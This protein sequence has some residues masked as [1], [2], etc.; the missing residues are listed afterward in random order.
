[1]RKG[2]HPHRRSG[3][4]LVGGLLLAGLTGPALAADPIPLNKLQDVQ[5]ELQETSERKRELDK[6]AARLAAEQKALQARLVNSARQVQSRETAVT[7]GEEKL[8]ALNAQAVAKQAALQARRGELAQSLAGLARLTRQPP[9]AMLLAP[10][11]ALDMVRATQ[12]VSAVVP[13]VQNRASTLRDDLAELTALRRAAAAEQRELVEAAAAMLDDRKKLEALQAET[14]QAAQSTAAERAEAVERATRLASEAKDLKSLV[15]R[16]AEEERQ[17]AKARAEREARERVA[18]LP[19]PTVPDS[20][21]LREGSAALPA[22]GRLVRKY[23]ETDEN[24]AL[25]KGIR[26][27]TRSSAQVVA[28]ADGKIVFAGPFRGYGQLLII[29]HGGGYH[30]LLAGFARIDRTVGQAVQAGEPVGQM[31]V[32]ETAKPTL[33][34]ELRLRGEPINPLPWLAAGERKVNG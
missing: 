25:L 4:L 21:N 18:R 14:N 2:D 26:I 20:F 32:D 1:M 11:S 5:R 16:L 19:P 27:E 12:L 24:G 8:A 28:P 29:A 15:D 31:A 9:E 13:E 3:P 17:A 7:R 30:S 10:G 6:Q 34:V 22:A 33:Y 23:G